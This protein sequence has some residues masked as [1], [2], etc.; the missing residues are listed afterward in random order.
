MLSLQGIPHLSPFWC[1]FCKPHMRTGCLCGCCHQ[2]HDLH[3]LS[4][5]CG[6]RVRVPMPLCADL[7]HLQLLPGPVQ[8][9]HSASRRGFLCSQKVPHAVALVAWGLQ[10]L[11]NLRGQVCAARCFLG[12]CTFHGS[13]EHC[14]LAE[15]E[16]QQKPVLTVVLWGD[17]W[18]Q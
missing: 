1:C 18:S 3:T 13:P 14:L 6:S 12:H 16:S 8:P 9:L 11:T 2:F 17:A 10:G 7:G 15:R 4:L 5:R